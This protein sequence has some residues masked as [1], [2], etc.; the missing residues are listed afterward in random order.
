MSVRVQSGSPRT[1]SMSRTG[2]PS[3]LA[4]QVVESFTEFPDP[5]E[6]STRNQQPPALALL[7]V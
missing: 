4:V 2:S 1:Y 5:K 3:I 7:Q 6:T